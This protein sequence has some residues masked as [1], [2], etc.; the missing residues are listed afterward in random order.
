MKLD[1]FKITGSGGNDL[2]Y[3]GDYIIVP[4]IRDKTTRCLRMDKH[5]SIKV[6]RTASDMAI[7]HG[8]FDP[9]YIKDQLCLFHGFDSQF[10]G[11]GTFK[12]YS[13][14]CTMIN[15]S[16]SIRDND[17]DSSINIMDAF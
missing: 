14:T 11:T 5:P 1:V 12:F 17:I 13:S 3:N 7:E 4:A 8:K 2:N 6:M 15:V 10:M 16:S 9:V